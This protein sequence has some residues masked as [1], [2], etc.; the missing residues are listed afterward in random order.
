MDK[1]LRYKKAVNIFRIISIPTLIALFV[2]MIISVCNS[3]EFSGHALVSTIS[4]FAFIVVEVI[5]FIIFD[6]IGFKLID[7]F[8]GKVNENDIEIAKNLLCR[9]KEI[10]VGEFLDYDAKSRLELDS[11]PLKIC[12]KQIIRGHKIHF[13]SVKAY[14]DLFEEI[15]DKTN[16][17]SEKDMV[18]YKYL[19]EL[20]PLLERNNHN[21]I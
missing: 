5:F 14:F 15:K 16:L 13:D 11:S 19:T 12:L 17:F 2:Y 9:I 21:E 3:Q 1:I 18:T 20:L 7:E 6:A 4:F 8:Y 10:D